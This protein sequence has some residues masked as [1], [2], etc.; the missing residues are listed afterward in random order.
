[1]SGAN[2]P[3]AGKRAASGLSCLWLAGAMLQAPAVAQPVSAA[4]DKAKLA[5]EVRTLTMLLEQQRVAQ[6]KAAPAPVPVPVPM[7][8]STS[9]PAEAGKDLDENLQLG[10][11]V[12]LDHTSGLDMT[13]N[14]DLSLSQ[15]ALGA[16]VTL[17][18]EVVASVL[19]KAEGALDRIF[20]DQAVASLKPEGTDW[21]LLF[22]QQ[23]FNHGLL[24]TRLI[25]DPEI[26]HFVE[27]T[28]PGI[29][30]SYATGEFTLGA[31]AAVLETV[32]EE[33]A[34]KDY[35]L[36][37]SLDWRKGPLL[38]RASGAV[39]RFATDADAALSWE[40]WKLQLD[41]EAFD[42]L[43]VWDTQERN[44]GYYLGAEYHPGGALSVAFRHDGL[45]SGTFSGLQTYRNA[46]GMTFSLKHDLFAACEFSQREDAGTGTD[47]QIALQVGLKS[48][49]E[50]PGFQ[51]K[52]LTQD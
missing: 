7:P 13:D 9:K 44:S 26:L 1:M 4:A 37:P 48:T 2:R 33:E 27:I 17:S 20:F 14:P 32:R 11:L 28:Q 30:A 6:P 43:P 31:G 47:R 23:T 38:L 3:A 41:A 34:S 21:T 10:G 5:E 40:V 50:L 52:T 51:R 19:L 25:S 45:M 8:E 12:S 46:A 15:V 16:N 42:R 29:S 24:S 39:S 36:L 22:G 18:R 35:A 49:L